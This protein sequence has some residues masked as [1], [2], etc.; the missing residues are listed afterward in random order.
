MQ[1]LIVAAGQG[2][3]LRDIAASKPLAMLHGRPLI[4]HVIEQA[5]AGGIDEFVVVTGYEAPPLEAFLRRFSMRGG[6]PI[7][8]V[9]NPDWRLANAVARAGLATPMIVRPT[10]SH[11][12][13]GLSLAEDDSALG[14]IRLGAK[15]GAYITAFHDYR[16]PD[17]FYRKYRMIFVDRKPFPYHLAISRQWMVHHRS[18]EMQDD[19]GRIA[20]ELA[21]LRDPGSALGERA[22]AAIA[23]IG[24][25]LDLDYGGVDF[26][27]T[28]DGQ[29]LL[30]EANAT[31][32]THLE[33]PDGPFAAK[34]VYIEPILRAF[35]GHL[36]ARARGG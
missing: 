8:V 7:H 32:L 24:R 28:A 23:A 22:L 33:P 21:F 29:V 19:A 20:E 27:L 9:R 14:Q 15:S 17:G 16:S 5:R 35:Q 30:F 25:R 3:R 11:G 10:G 13:A 36:T 26:S 6:F 31:M 12:G 34:N 1:G 2:T 4:Q 18:A